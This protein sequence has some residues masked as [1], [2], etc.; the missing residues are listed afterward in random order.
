MSHGAKA[1]ARA[2]I[3]NS[4]EPVSNAVVSPSADIASARPL[5]LPSPT[6][7]PR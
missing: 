1:G 6:R 3:N 4:P 2:L 7:S 5:F